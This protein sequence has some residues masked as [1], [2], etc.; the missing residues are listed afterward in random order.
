MKCNHLK[1]PMFR[2]NNKGKLSGIMA[3]TTLTYLYFIYCVSHIG[4]YENDNS[5]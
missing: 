3:K 5:I 4:D 2:I 1:L